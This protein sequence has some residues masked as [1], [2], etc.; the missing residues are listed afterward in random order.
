MNEMINKVFKRPLRKSYYKF[1]AWEVCEILTEERTVFS[2]STWG[3]RDGEMIY[4]IYDSNMGISFRKET[5]KSLETLSAIV[6]FY[7]GAYPVSKERE[8][9]IFNNFDRMFGS[10]LQD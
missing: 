6:K 3:C 4:A 5:D 1:G 7:D 9:E 10:N 2:L 8:E